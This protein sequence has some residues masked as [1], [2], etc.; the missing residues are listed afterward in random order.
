MHRIPFKRSG[1]YQFRVRHGKLLRIIQ[2]CTVNATSVGSLIMNKLIVSHSRLTDK[3]R[4]YPIILD[5]CHANYCRSLRNQITRQGTQHVREIMQFS[6]V[7]FRSPPVTAIRQE[8]IVI[9]TCIMDGIKQ[10]LKIIKRYAIQFAFR[11]LGYNYC[12]AEPKRKEY[13]QFSHR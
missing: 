4:Q 3:I 2:K 5:F 8:V 10:I 1:K 9:L 13:N 6:F 11:V 7:L 12:N